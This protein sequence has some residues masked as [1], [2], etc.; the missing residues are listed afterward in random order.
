MVCCVGD[1]TEN[2]PDGFTDQDIEV[3]AVVKCTVNETLTE[4]ALET[5]IG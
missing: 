2:S 5:D 4:I 1:E 3:G